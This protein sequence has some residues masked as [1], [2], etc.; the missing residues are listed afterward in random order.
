[1]FGDF[2][3]CCSSTYLQGATFAQSPIL[4]EAGE[5]DISSM[6]E[7]MHPAV[8]PAIETTEDG[9]LPWLD[10][11]WEI[12]GLTGVDKRLALF[13]SRLSAHGK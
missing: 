8:I 4:R 11:L 9:K 2:K 13:H 6:C 5:S 7:R 10:G 3:G 12:L 1:M